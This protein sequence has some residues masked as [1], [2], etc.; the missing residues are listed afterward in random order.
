VPAE[1]IGLRPSKPLLK[2][3]REQEDEF[4]VGEPLEGTHRKIHRNLAPIIALERDSDTGRLL[5]AVG[6]T[7]G[8]ARFESAPIKTCSIRE[9]THQR[10][11]SLVRGVTPHT[12]YA[13]LSP[14][15]LIGQNND[16]LHLLRL[17]ERRGI[18]SDRVWSRHRLLRI[19]SVALPY[20]DGFIV[21]QFF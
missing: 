3:F 9:T 4:L 10:V 21:Q 18:D 13:R 11:I 8:A 14:H 12:D 15:A 7:A 6:E 1:E 2:A 20:P 5:P 17:R 16:L 19:P